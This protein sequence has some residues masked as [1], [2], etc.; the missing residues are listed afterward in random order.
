MSEPGDGWIDRE[1]E[2]EFPGLALMT[3][4]CEGP[5][6]EDPGV[7][8]RLATVASRIRGRSAIELR[9]EPVPAAY[10]AFYRQV[11]IDPDVE[12][13]PVEAAI[14]RRLF[15]GG[16]R[17]TDPLQAALELAVLE[18]SAPVYALDAQALDGPPGIRPAGAGEEV[19]GTDGVMRGLPGRLVIAD[20]A[21]PLCRLFDAA[22]GRARAGASTG[23]L[24]LVS[25]G[26]PGVA[27]IVL[28]EALDVAAGAIGA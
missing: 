9:R 16:V 20:A 13:T 10:R 8:E 26:V 11:G 18:T 1:L 23:S 5:V 7:T 4:G 25:V 17:R 28:D 6:R 15:E 2:L 14:G 3:R 21:G 24:L 27:P 22:H 12:M 19:A